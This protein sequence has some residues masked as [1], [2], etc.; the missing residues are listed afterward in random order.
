MASNIYA[1]K[2]ILF[3]RVMHC[4]YDFIA[5]LE[6]MNTLLILMHTPAWLKSSISADELVNDLEYGTF[7]T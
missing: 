7:R 3:S 6:R 4:D 1:G 5:K 2:M